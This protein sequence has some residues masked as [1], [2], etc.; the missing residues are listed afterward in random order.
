MEAAGEAGAVLL[1]AGAAQLVERGAQE[2]AFAARGIDD[3]Q[4]RQLVGA[5]AGDERRQRRGRDPP[6][7]RVGRIEDAG[8]AARL[9]PHH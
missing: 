9:A 7:R 2:D 6:R 1:A 3:A 5:A 4:A 8:R